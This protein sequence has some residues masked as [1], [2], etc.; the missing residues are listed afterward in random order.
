VY[1]VVEPDR[2]VLAELARRIDAG[3]IRPIVGEVF[4]LEQGREA[5]EV[6]RRPGTPGKV[7]LRVRN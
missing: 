5:F 2:S 3:E 4:P 7:V 1:F 6:K